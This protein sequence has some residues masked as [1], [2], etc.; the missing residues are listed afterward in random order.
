MVSTRIRHISKAGAGGGF[1]FVGGDGFD[2]AGDGEGV[3][4]AAFAADEV[5]ASAL[6]G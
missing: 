6:A 5:Q 2:Q 4:D 1:V 3:A